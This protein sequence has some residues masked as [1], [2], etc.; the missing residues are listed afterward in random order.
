M[1]KQASDRRTGW[2]GLI[3]GVLRPTLLA[4]G[5]VGIER[6]AALKGK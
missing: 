4:E 2:A 3:V 1:A 6:F 5:W